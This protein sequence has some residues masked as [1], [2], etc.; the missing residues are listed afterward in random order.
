[1][2]TY[3]VFNSKYRIAFETSVEYDNHYTEVEKWIVKYLPSVLSEL[4][5]DWD[6]AQCSRVMAWGYLFIELPK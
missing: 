6:Y 3:A 4:G 5:N 1:M 2:E